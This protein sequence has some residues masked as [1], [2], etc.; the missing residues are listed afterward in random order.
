MPAPALEWYQ[1]TIDLRGLQIEQSY[2]VMV[3]HRKPPPGFGAI[4]GSLSL[5]ATGFLN[6]IQDLS[7]DFSSP[8]ST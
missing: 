4:P 8:I 2:R 7:G 3:P 6:S 1:R 5:K